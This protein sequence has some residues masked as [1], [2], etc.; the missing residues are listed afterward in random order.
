MY[1]MV[2]S[3]DQW[4]GVILPMLCVGQKKGAEP[5]MG[6]RESEGSGDSKTVHKATECPGATANL[7]LKL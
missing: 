2:G 7:K 5:F 4:P 3:R 6:V 1:Q